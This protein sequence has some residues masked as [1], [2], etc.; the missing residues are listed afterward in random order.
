VSAPARR[1]LRLGQYGMLAI[2]VAVADLPLLWIILNAFRPDSDNTAF[3]PRL[4]PSRVTLEHFESLFTLYGFGKYLLNSVV[5]SVLATA[6]AVVAGTAAAYAL[7]R[8]RGLVLSVVGRAA[9]LAYIVPP[10]LILVP[11][12]QILFGAGLGDNRWALAVLY[13]A[14][15]LPFAL[16]MLRS[17]FGGVTVDVEEAAMIDG[18]S[19]F[20]AFRR[21]VVP[22]AAP[23]I[24]ST[25]I[26]TFTAAWSEYLFVST[27]MTSNEKLTANPA[28][29]LLM[30][31]MGT[32]S[33][34][35]LMSAAVVIVAPLVVLFIIAQRWLVPGIGAGAVK[36]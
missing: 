23:G 30:G 18:C 13:V 19:R 27:L 5:V 6:G 1:G 29:Y 36:G 14:T 20:A 11:I 26:F 17:Y 32:T 3:P 16:W 22:Q 35:L 34:G 33:V 25:A 21:V 15:L 2:V 10:I 7:A 12:T 9:L 28:V 24:L 8:F 4:R 31:H